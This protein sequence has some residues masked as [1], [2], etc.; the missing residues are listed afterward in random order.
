MSKSPS[1]FQAVTFCLLH[2]V[3]KIL[4]HFGSKV[5]TFHVKTLLHFGSKVVTFHIKT[6]IHFGSKGVTFRVNVTFCNI[7]PPPQKTLP[8]LGFTDSNNNL[9]SNLFFHLIKAAA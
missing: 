9:K 5:G 3:L 2:L 8:S 6:L 1:Y 7:T 4:F